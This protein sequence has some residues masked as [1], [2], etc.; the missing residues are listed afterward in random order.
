MRRLIVSFCCMVCFAA[1]VLA[2]G[3]AETDLVPV[4]VQL[5]SHLDAYGVE[6]PYAEGMLR[7]D[8][9]LAYT[10]ISLQADVLDAEDTV[11]GE[12]LGYLVRACGDALLD[13]SLQPGTQAP[14]S[15]QL[16][17]YEA[18]AVIDHVQLYPAA[19]ASE[20]PPLVQAE[21]PGITQVTDAEVV[22]VE[23]QDEQT[24]LYSGGCYRDV[25]TK[26][27]WFEY[28]LSS[29]KSTPVEHPRAA[30]VTD[31]MRLALELDDPLI[32]NRSYL[33]FAPGQRRAVYQSALNTLASA[34]P[35]GSFKRVLYDGLFNITLQGINFQ[36][37]SGTLLAYYHGGYGDDVLYLVANADGRQFSQHPTVAVPSKIVPGFAANGRGVVIAT[38]I[39]GVTG[40]FLKVTSNDFTIPLFEAE[41]PGNNWPAPVYEIT[42]DNQRWIFIARPVDGEPRLQC[43]N[44][45]SKQLHDYTALP[46]N[47]ASDERAWMWL[48][49]NNGTLALAA[50]GVR[51]GLWLIDLS[52]FEACD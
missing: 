38:T 27:P 30:E 31:A 15:V 39:D 45:D 22:A 35:D 46:L 8:G 11:I 52:Q 4:D 49:P 24:L 32:Y 14:F 3:N 16:E 50:N 42:P 36:K 41:P 2:Q 6:Q 10:Q 20:A 19:T 5:T 25:F 9:D 1:T 18:D 12:G 43:F 17:P 28:S 48:S 23:W 26:R 44:P 13:Y 21:I 7:N 37:D 47:L 34:E 29:G 40:Y 51:G 33:T